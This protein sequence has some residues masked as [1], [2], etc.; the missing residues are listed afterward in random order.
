MSL[1]IPGQLA[2][3]L[4]ELGYTWPKS[5]EVQLLQLG[6]DWLRLAT[7]LEQVVSEVSEQAAV[8]WRQNYG[9]AVAAFEARW[10][11]DDSAQAVLAR[12]G[13]GAEVLAAGLMLCA[14]VVLALKVNVIVQLTILAI[15]IAQAIA[16]S[17][18]T[19]G[20][21]LLEIPVFKKITGMAVNLLVDQ[22]LEAILG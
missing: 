7:E 4:N 3:L 9:D 5:N 20:A 2:D 16:T 11:A 13:Q 18:P 17:V 10:S 6:Q 12:G 14:G 15:Q 22:A 21:S 19:F 1:Q 8:V